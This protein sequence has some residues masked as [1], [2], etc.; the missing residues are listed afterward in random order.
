VASDAVSATLSHYTKEKLQMR[1]ITVSLFA[2]VL[3]FAL[4]AM[5][6]DTMSNSSSSPGSSAKSSKSSSKASTIK[7]WV[8]DEKCGAAGAAAD[9][10]DCAK[11]CVAGGQKIVFVT[12]SDKK[13][14][15]VDNPDTLKDHV[16]HHVQVKGHVDADAGTLHVNSV[17]M[18][19]S[20]K[21]AASS[22]SSNPS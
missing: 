16:G 8:S 18:A 1:K 5:A 17:K 3:A 4:S 22:S 15:N 2:L 13:V 11:K 9:K 21:K 10:A 19:A 12:D 6:Q 20:S 14:L 7:G